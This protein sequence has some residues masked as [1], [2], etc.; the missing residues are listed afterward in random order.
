MT[1]FGE[2]LKK[3]SSPIPQQNILNRVLLEFL[4]LCSLPEG[5]L[6]ATTDLVET[7]DHINELVCTLHEFGCINPNLTYTHKASVNLLTLVRAVIIEFSIKDDSWLVSL[8][9]INEALIKYRNPFNYDDS[10]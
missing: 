7:F 2:V 9:K 4:Y 5:S 1:T 6:V 3:M 8:H 10:F